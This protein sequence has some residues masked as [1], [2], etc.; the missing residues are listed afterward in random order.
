MMVCRSREGRQLQIH[1]RDVEG[2]NMIV[3]FERLLPISAS[4]TM[5]TSCLSI[6]TERNEPQPESGLRRER[7][8]YGAIAHSGS[9]VETHH[10]GPPYGSAERSECGL[11]SAPVPCVRRG[12]VFGR[13]GIGGKVGFARFVPMCV[14][15]LHCCLLFLRLIRNVKRNMPLTWI[16][17]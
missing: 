12:C 16:D 14:A 15:S 11:L 9:G 7:I 3:Q 8:L 10:R 6:D 13:G 17:K 2:K 5:A 4:A 1:Q